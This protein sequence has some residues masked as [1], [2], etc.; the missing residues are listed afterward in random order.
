MNIRHVE[1]ETL[2]D[3]SK[4]RFVTKPTKTKKFLSYFFFIR[5]FLYLNFK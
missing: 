5:C 3:E 1:A 2:K 4:N